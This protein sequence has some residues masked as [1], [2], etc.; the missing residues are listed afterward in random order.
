MQR[1]LRRTPDGRTLERLP[2][3]TIVDV[4]GQQGAQMPAD[5]TF[6]YQGP[7][8]A[9][10]AQRA[11]AQARAATAEAPFAGTTAAADARKAEADARIAEAQAA[12]AASGE[13]KQTAET[14]KEANKGFQDTRL[15]DLAIQEIE[16]LYTQGPGST[17]GIYGAADFF[18]TPQNQRF[19]RAGNQVRAFVKGVLQF[20]G[21]ENNTP[22]E[23]LMNFGPYVPQSADFDGTIRDKISA[24]KRLRDNGY[25]RAVAQLGGVP[26]RDGR[27]VPLPQGV[28]V[29]PDVVNTVLSSDSPQNA[30]TALRMGNNMPTRVPGLADVGGGATIRNPD[31]LPP[32][33]V[34]DID[35]LTQSLV[36]QGGGRIDPQAFVAARAQIDQQYGLA[37]TA[38]EE[39]VQWATSVNDYL[40][41]GG[42]TIP[43]GV[44]PPER[45]MSAGE[46]ARN[47]LINNPI[48]GAIIGASNGITAGLGD[49]FAPEQMMAMR[50]AQGGAMMAGEI[51]GAIGSTVALGGAGR[52]LAGRVAPSL[53]QGGGRG[54]FARNI[55]TDATYG[56]AYGQNTQGDAATGTALGVAGS[57]A[58]QGLARGLGVAVGGAQISDA[59]RRLRERGVPISVA[60]QMG[61]GRAEDAMQ[62]IPIVGDMSRAR[63]LD[64][65]RGFNQ[66]AFQEAG[67]PI[68]ANIPSIAGRDGIDSLD[69][70]V[71]DAYNSAL[72]GRSFPVDRQFDAEVGFLGSARNELPLDVQ[73]RAD[74][75]VENHTNLID[76]SGRE[77]SAEMYQRA[78]RGLGKARNNANQIAGEFD[79]PYRE[80]MTGVLDAYDNLLMRKGGDDV[81]EGLTAANAA[82][83]NL[84]ILEDASLDRAKVG[85]QSGEV[86]I[87]TPAQLLA[88]TRKSEDKYGGGQGLRSLAEDAQEVLPST[89]PNSG[90]T[91]RA[92][93]A[94]I[95]GT[96]GI[97]AG[98]G[99]L[100]GGSDGAQS[101]A[102]GGGAAAALAAL[103]GTRGGQRALEQILITRPQALQQAGQGF[104]RRSG[105]FGSAGGST[106]LQSY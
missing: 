1:E 84:K 53:L 48:G 39:L 6:Q 41:S 55:G 104:R 13:V 52:A 12:A 105:L 5:P 81:T 78:R 87:F 67:T 51:G 50:D 9:A 57:A 62:S 69:R 23:A 83:K 77:L 65:F 103:L 38:P 98:G 33:Y 3:G 68:R 36:S 7:Q 92:I 54:Q 37:P 16:T 99:G 66:A 63:Q 73:S 82:N 89:L 88:A 60:R 25:Q 27:I 31:D 21:Q 19:D 102:V 22:A 75:L 47:N 101:G 11:Q 79:Q 46:T 80:T 49:A 59:A 86:N 95:A 97:G 35:A 4:S 56:A 61:L 17:S 18:G 45:I 44:L 71:G 42:T 32:G 15:L 72:G 106:A 8:A 24:L 85:T 64:S 43:S 70:A 29:T 26:D 76:Q 100:V 40:D 74:K 96:A 2:D 28:A 90:T 94:G 20:T 93:M 30:L 10:E 14:R 58:G 91:D 34:D